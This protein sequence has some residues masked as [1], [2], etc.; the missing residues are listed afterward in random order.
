MHKVTL[1]R[2]DSSSNAGHHLDS[3]ELKALPAA[4]LHLNLETIL[5]ARPSI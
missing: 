1:R 2:A 4:E 3:D 5:M